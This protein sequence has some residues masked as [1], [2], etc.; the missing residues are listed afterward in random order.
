MQHSDNES[1]SHDCELCGCTQCQVYL[2]HK[3]NK[4]KI[5]EELHS[6]STLKNNNE[7]LMVTMDLQKALLM[8]KVP[9]KDSYFSKKFVLF[10][11]TFA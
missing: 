1:K 8:P 2:T 5:S 11:E 10:N 3:V 9:T 4:N 6:D 7:Y